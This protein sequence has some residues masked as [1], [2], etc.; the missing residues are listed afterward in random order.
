MYKGKLI[1]FSF[2]STFWKFILLQENKPY[3]GIKS[4]I[5]TFQELNIAI[6]ETFFGYEYC[7]S[8]GFCTFAP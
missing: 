5:L 3:R 6:A 8:E 7:I 1:Y 4:L 2:Q